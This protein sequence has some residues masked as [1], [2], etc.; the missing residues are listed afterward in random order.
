MRIHIKE[1]DSGFFGFPIGVLNLSSGEALETETNRELMPSCVYVRSED[2]DALNT[3]E[4]RGY[5][6]TGVY[7]LITFSKTL[8]RDVLYFDVEAYTSNEYEPLKSLSRQAGHTSRFRQDLRFLPHFDRLYDTWVQNSVKG[9]LA[10]EVF[11]SSCDTKATGLI[12]LK[13]DGDCGRVGLLAV[14][15][16]SQGKGLATNLLKSVESYCYRKKVFRINVAT[17]G[18]N[19]GAI[20]CY[21][22]NGYT[23]SE[24]KYVSHY[25]RVDL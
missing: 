25:W 20:K 21:L 6:S 5:T 3:F 11:I 8:C 7:E 10:D 12:T 19:I 23:V 9:S 14:D 16:L 4:L 1:W 18:D 17:Q 15:E 22:K 24:R 13:V 2:R